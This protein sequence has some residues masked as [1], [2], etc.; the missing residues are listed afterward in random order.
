VLTNLAAQN[1]LF[2]HPL[3]GGLQSLKLAE[4]ESGHRYHVYVDPGLASPPNFTLNTNQEAAAEAV[5]GAF[6]KRLT[7]GTL[8][9]NLKKLVLDYGHVSNEGVRALINSPKLKNTVIDFTGQLYSQH[10]DIAQGTFAMQ[11][12]AANWRDLAV[13]NM[14]AAR[15]QGGNYQMPEFMREAINAGRSTRQWLMRQYVEQ[16]EDLLTR[17]ER[18]ALRGG[19]NNGGGTPP[20]P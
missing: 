8:G 18:R 9:N 15:S 11:V 12:D 4:P 3:M 16:P 7:G 2:K 6:V 13:H 5:D 17:A 20:R 1:A 14:Q 10:H 19:G